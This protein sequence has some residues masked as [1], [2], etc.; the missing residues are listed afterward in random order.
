METALHAAETLFRV[1]SLVLGLKQQPTCS[2]ASWLLYW[3]GEPHT[4]LVHTGVGVGTS[5]V[6]VAV[7]D[8]VGVL[9]AV[10]VSVG[11]GVGVGVAVRVAVGVGVGV[12]VGDVNTS[13][14]AK[15]SFK[16]PLVVEFEKPSP[17]KRM[18]SFP[19]VFQRADPERPPG[20]TFGLETL[21]VP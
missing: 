17:P 5:G 21:N 6:L 10:I 3:P 20:T 1:H 12:G 18:G 8:C 13:A 11:V 15:A 4:S 16:Y 19:S 9:V 2:Q 14:S 7:I